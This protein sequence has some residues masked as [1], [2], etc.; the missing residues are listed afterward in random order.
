[1]VHLC[2]W[3]CSIIVDSYFEF[4]VN[5]LNVSILKSFNVR[6]ALVKINIFILYEIFAFLYVRLLMLKVQIV[7]MK[8]LLL[9]N[10]FK[11][12]R[13]SGLLAYVQVPTS[14]PLLKSLKWVGLKW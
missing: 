11:M 7:P 3:P 12:V 4:N 9:Y 13:I 10:V 14:K 2:H 6:Y 8:L 1:M 5:I